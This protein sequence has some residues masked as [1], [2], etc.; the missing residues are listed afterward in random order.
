MPDPVA[1]TA[2]TMIRAAPGGS[3]RTAQVTRLPD[4]VQ[5]PRFAE[6]ESSSRRG[7]TTST[8]LTL[9]ATF[10]PRL[11][12]RIVY[13]TRSPAVT[14]ALPRTVL[15][16]TRSAVGGAGAVMQ[17]RGYFALAVAV[18]IWWPGTL[19]VHLTAWR[20]GMFRIAKANVTTPGL[21]TVGWPLL[22]GAGR[23]KLPRPTGTITSAWLAFT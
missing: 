12:T 3:S 16:R 19:T 7:A 10:G 17:F 20:L 23:T 2:T 15:R 1:R 8:I 21:K 5:L 4:V 6:A 9:R 11:T 22:I 14:F 13:V 18:R